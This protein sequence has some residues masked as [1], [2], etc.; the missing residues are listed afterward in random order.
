MIITITLSTLLLTNILMIILELRMKVSYFS[1][2]F[3]HVFAG[4]DEGLLQVAQV[5]LAKRSQ[6][7]DDSVQR[8]RRA[9]GDATNRLAT[10][11]PNGMHI[12]FDRLILCFAFRIIPCDV[13][14][15]QRRSS[16]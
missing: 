16:R 6:L 5:S 4:A 12:I 1:F 13:T 15:P 7:P 9:L 10:S 3:V 14:F 8:K 11:T 2:F